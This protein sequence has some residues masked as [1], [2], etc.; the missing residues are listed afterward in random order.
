[1]ESH[2]ALPGTT[3][4]VRSVTRSTQFAGMWGTI[5]KCFG[6]PDHPALDVRLENGRLELFWF[7]QL[8]RAG[9]TPNDAHFWEDQKGARSGRGGLPSAT[10]CEGRR[11]TDL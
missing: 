3:V 1:L 11:A 4:R 8:D 5:A 10:A 6:S 2:E 9:E 7:Y